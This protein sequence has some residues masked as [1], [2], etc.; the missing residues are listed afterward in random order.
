MEGDSYS[1]YIV[2]RPPKT[3][4]AVKKVKDNVLLL[5][6][7]LNFKSHQGTV[8]RKECM[9]IMYTFQEKSTT[10]L[11]LYDFDVSTLFSFFIA[12]YMIPL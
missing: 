9:K 12:I 10:Y 2:G 1:S 8:Q 7:L 4:V 3:V 11:Q 6:P 5:S